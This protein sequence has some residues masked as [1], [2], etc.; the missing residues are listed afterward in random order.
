[1]RI[2]SGGTLR[3]AT[4][5]EELAELMGEDYEETGEAD[6]IVTHCPAHNDRNPSLV[7]SLGK[8]RSR[9]GK[10][11]LHCRAGCSHMEVLGALIGMNIAIDEI[12]ESDSIS[13]LDEALEKGGAEPAA[14]APGGASDGTGTA[15][16]TGAQAT[17]AAGAG[18]GE[19]KD[20]E[21]DGGEKED[22]EGD[23]DDKPDPATREQFRQAGQLWAA[24]VDIKGT[25]AETYLTKERSLPVPA[26]WFDAVRESDALRFSSGGVLITKRGLNQGPCM[27]ARI[28]D[29][30]GNV[31]GY[32]ITPL[33]EKGRKN[34][35]F[36]IGKSKNAAIRVQCRR[37]LMHEK[38]LPALVIAEGLE[39][40]L[41]RLVPED[42]PIELWILCGNLPQRV[43][44]WVNQ[45][46]ADRRYHAEGSYDWR[47]RWSHVELAIDRD[48]EPA[49]HVIA[50]MVNAATRLSVL[51]LLTPGEILGKG[52][53]LN[54]LLVTE[55]CLDV[56][57][58]VITA[59]V[60]TPGAT[61]MAPAGQ[62]IRLVDEL[63]QVTWRTTE[64]RT[65]IAANGVLYGWLTETGAWSVVATERL[66]AEISAFARD[67]FE[68]S[69]EGKVVPW[70]RVSGRTVER[71][72]SLAIKQATEP[73]L[74]QPGSRIYRLRPESGVE[75]LDDW[76]AFYDGGML[77]ICSREV[78]VAGQDVFALN[79]LAADPDR[80]GE[81]PVEFERMLHE[82]FE[83]LDGFDSADIRRQIDR[84]YEMIGY[85]IH[86]GRLNL[87]KLIFLSG[88]TGT[89]KSVVERVIEAIVGPAGCA[90]ITLPQLGEPHGTSMLT[91]AA[92]I[93]LSD[94]RQT[95]DGHWHAPKGNVL[96]L[97]LAITGGDPV[98]VNPKNRPL[99]P[100]RLTQCVIAISNSVPTY[101][102]D[103]DGAIGR[104]IESIAFGPPK[105]VDRPADPE[106]ADRIIKGELS[107]IVGR[108]LDGLDRLRRTGRFTT[109][110][111]IA[112][113][114]QAVTEQIEP[115]RRFVQYLVVVSGEHL[116]R[117]ELYDGY[118]R[119]TRSEGRHPLSLQPFSNQ[120][121]QAFL[122]VHKYQLPVQ[123]ER[124]RIGGE[125][126]EIWSDL[127]WCEDTPE[128][129]RRDTARIRPA[130]DD[131]DQALKS[132]I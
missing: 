51:R 10:L 115:L 90:A 4:T 102:M 132:K 78:A 60:I 81:M 48:K 83:T 111:G 27:L 103:G 47:T 35:R 25:L 49:S 101:L 58:A 110:P 88:A 22:E 44:S 13:D 7:V 26:V 95:S 33:D 37:A 3:V 21:E 68:I 40:G 127:A 20:D 77:N 117:K 1:V 72:G 67:S 46:A 43:T 17:P 74:E 120:L 86:G 93:K 31:T 64:G 65:R 84:V 99:Y 76:L 91:G 66:A 123:R 119:W 14:A 125:Q 6:T 18:N 98:P 55:G 24:A 114:Q 131:L 42:R 12:R 16:G 112:R 2:V 75:T 126:V 19:G 73:G 53:D 34:G 109:S 85:A 122:A 38:E 63:V 130:L 97:I 79:R 96:G 62:E 11:L 61:A 92:V 69:A 124:R 32:Q 105:N 23:D 106:L 116:T 118:V 89:G 108:A 50:R 87:Q 113:Q 29:E 54:D 52:A 41:S 128:D 71:I 94:I 107:G 129:I 15:G 57:K 104:R 8:K 30:R 121:R 36:I 5:P 100:L 56:L 39:T 82:A 80:F 28:T 9:K 45:L 59:P 70:Q